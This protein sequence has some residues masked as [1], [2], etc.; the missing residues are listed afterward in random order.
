[1]KKVLKMMLI[2]GVIIT[3]GFACDACSMYEYTSLQN[4]SYAAFFYNSRLFNGYSHLGGQPYYTLSPASAFQAKGTHFSQFTPVENENDYEL[5]TTY[6][7]RVNINIDDTYNLLLILPHRT[8]SLYYA[9]VYPEVGPVTTREIVIKGIGDMV[10]GLERLNNYNGDFIHRLRYGF[11]LKVPTGQYQKRDVHN[12]MYDPTIQPGTGSWDFILRGTYTAV[13][14]QLVGYS[15]FMNARINT[16]SKIKPNAGNSE[17]VRY[18]FGNRL[19]INFNAFYIQKFGDLQLIPKTG[20]YYE[21][22]AYDWLYE[23]DTQQSVAG[24]GGRTLFWNIGL[25][26]NY[27]FLTLQTLWQKPVTELLHDEQMSNAGRFMIG[28]VYN[29]DI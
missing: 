25:D 10:I 20:L 14:K 24:T 18:K 15:F 27:K 3:K 8:A 17:V 9:E 21:S 19:N 1:M 4:R 26:V 2:L 5:Y 7:A 11:G 16:K 13:Y 23:P 22:A 6:E 29:F 28:L 12:E